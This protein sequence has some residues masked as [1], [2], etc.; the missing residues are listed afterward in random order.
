MPARRLPPQELAARCDPARLDT[1]ASEAPPR[2]V[3]QERARA[4]VKFG[5]ATPHPGFHLFVMGPPG[6]GRRSLARRVIEAQAAHNGVQR[7]D[8]VYVND[9]EHAH[10]PVALRLPAGQGTQ[11]R[12]DMR[13]LVRDLRTLIAAVFESEEYATQVERLNDEFKERS[14]QAFGEVAQEAQRRG[15]AMIRT[16]VGFTFAPQ[17]DGEVMPPE[18]FEALP[19][20]RHAELQKAI[21]EVQEQL[22]RVLRSHM[23][24]RKE[25]ADRVR[26]LDRSTTMLAVEH[27]V[28]ELKARYAELPKVCRYLDAVH[29]DVIENAGDFRSHGDDGEDAD[30]GKH[31]H[32]SGELGR[33][34][35][36]VVLDASATPQVPIV[37]ADLP[38]VPNLVGRVDHIARFGAL[39][40]DFRLIKG[41]AL[42]RANG[43]YLLVDAVKLLQQPFAWQALKR[44]LLGREIRIESLGELYSMISTVQ[45]EPEPIPLQVKVVIVGERWVCHLLQA[46]D[47]EFDELFRVLAD[48]GDDMP[49]A[50][51]TEQELAQLLAGALREQQM[52]PASTPALA[53]LIDHG[54]RLAG[55]TRR[56]T[57]Q[58]RRLLDVLFEAEHVARGRGRAQ[59]D[60][61]DVAAAIAAGRARASRVHERLADAVQ[62]D[63]LMID[64]AGARVGQ[65]NGLSVYEVGNELFGMVT[66]ITATSR[67]GDGQVID[68]QRETNLGGP[69]HA[70]G[71]LILSSFLAAR[72]TR[73]QPHAIVASLVFEQTYGLVEGDSASLAELVA[74]L[75]SIADV[76][77]KQCFA[78]TG[79]VNQFGDVQAIGGVNEKVEGF[80]D[81]CTAR[82]LDGTHGVLIPE[83][84][85]S[86][87]ML[88][89]DVIEAVAAGRFAIH[90]VRH[91]DDAV[92]LLTG[93]P[94]GDPTQPH[95]DTVNGRIAMRLQEYAR[96]RRG[97]ARVT[98]RQRVVQIRRIADGEG[99]A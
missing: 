92:E 20:E 55:D 74:L 17:K 89:D 51:D 45:L 61:D 43:G 36:N 68:I 97:E 37:E 67:L 57:A 71:V 99:K 83:S 91:V 47:P 22:V 6:S 44:A 34:E 14:E 9:F 73:R 63:I 38:T 78:V 59:V 69:V 49:R 72:Y 24:M 21:A 98:R 94:A 13:A 7:S 86:H 75:S 8:W 19:E 15:L 41:G 25:H 31:E 3:G 76:P 95:A 23:R 11:L 90:A 77:V 66:R 56:V 48:L 85:A 58:V 93:L 84:N 70:K 50:A 54:S 32:A 12:A 1:A 29:A 30:D 87:L 42:H 35:V 16:P 28:D 88:R 5:I 96:L 79:S 64:T 53:R 18:A 62:R 52:L 46:H 39:L 60:A 65:V 80:F 82:G 27:A 26:A 33:Y 4:A 10:Q 40:T 2:I 81:V